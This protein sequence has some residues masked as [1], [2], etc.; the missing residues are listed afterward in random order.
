[1]SPR[2]TPDDARSPGA[3]QGT[4]PAIAEPGVE[5]SPADVSPDSVTLQ[6][7]QSDGEIRVSIAGD[8]TVAYPVTGGTVT[9][10][11]D[12]VDHFLATVPGASRPDPTS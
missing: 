12:Q 10:P 1:M 8:D 2:P 3:D 7:G 11:A 9:I 5:A 6:V 4:D